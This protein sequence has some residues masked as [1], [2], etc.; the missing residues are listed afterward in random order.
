MVHLVQTTGTKNGLVKSPVKNTRCSLER[1]RSVA[2]T[3]SA[4]DVHSKLPLSFLQTWLEKCPE[5]SLHTAGSVAADSADDSPFFKYFFNLTVV[6]SPS[7][8]MNSLLSTLPAHVEKTWINL[9]LDSQS[10]ET[11]L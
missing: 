5:V 4:G 6:F 10:A 3:T 11:L 8:R 7:Q 2:G 1:P 9:F